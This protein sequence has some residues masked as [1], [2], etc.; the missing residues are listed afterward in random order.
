MAEPRVKTSAAP[1]AAS[2]AARR[3]AGDID[4]DPELFERLR[5]LR[6]ELADREGVPPF[7]IFSDISLAEMAALLPETEAEF[8]GIHGVGRHKLERYGPSFLDEIRRFASQ[9]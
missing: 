8:R 6:K 3:K 4:Y 1:K 5:A 7:V 2:R 9:R